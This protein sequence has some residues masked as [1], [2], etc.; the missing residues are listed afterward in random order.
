MSFVLILDVGGGSGLGDVP[1]LRVFSVGPKRQRITRSGANP[2]SFVPPHTDGTNVRR[3]VGSH[4]L[5][6]QEIATG[7]VEQDGGNQAAPTE[8]EVAPIAASRQEQE[9]GEQVVPTAEE[10]LAIASRSTRA[11]LKGFNPD[12]IR[13]LEAH[14]Q[15]NAGPPTDE[16]WLLVATGPLK[17]SEAVWKRTFVPP[18]LVALSPLRACSSS[19]VVCA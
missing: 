10:V 15:I 6:S 17:K 7:R 19:D 4:R 14:I 11:S 8:A 9:E 12:E 5:L 18:P 16:Y 2:L 13:R 3:M 1:R